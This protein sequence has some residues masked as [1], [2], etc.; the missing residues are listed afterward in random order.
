MGSAYLLWLAW[1]VAN[2]EPV[3][4]TAVNDRKNRPISL[5]QAAAF[6][7]VNPKAWILVLGA[8]TTYTDIAELYCRRYSPLLSP[9]QSSA[10][11]R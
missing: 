7:W 4:A 8:V 5:L 9:L 6:Q 10:S 11:F 2:A 1:R 3:A